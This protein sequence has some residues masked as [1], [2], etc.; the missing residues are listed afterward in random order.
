MTQQYA[1]VSS[2][3]RS[4]N[5]R[6]SRALDEAIRLLELADEASDEERFADARG[7]FSKARI[8]I[9]N[10]ALLLNRKRTS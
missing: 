5:V 2:T 3:P 9:Q 4:S 1:T 7:Y 6:F 10:A 8:A